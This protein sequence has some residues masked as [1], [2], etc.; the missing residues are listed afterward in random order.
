VAN[1]ASST[2]STGPFVLN[3]NGNDGFGSAYIV[4]LSPAL[5]ALWAEKVGTGA[6]L[7]NRASFGSLTADGAGNVYLTGTYMGTVG[8][9][10][11]YLS[12][13]RGS[14][15]IF[16]VK[17]NANGALQWVIS[18]GGSKSDG[19][20]GIAV[21]NAGGVYVTGSIDSE[22]ST[23]YTAKFDATHSLKTSTA[24]AFLW[25]LTQP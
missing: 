10:G 1:F 24:A 23:N 4:K 21:D 5:N 25:K 8:F 7:A 22:G 20:G 2:S 3:G 15:D 14:D 16:A 18:A 13:N 17:L 12:S 11:T 6:N 19:G 9:F